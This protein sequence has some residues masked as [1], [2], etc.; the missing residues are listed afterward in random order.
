M[1][2][3]K[4]RIMLTSIMS[5][6]VALQLIFIIAARNHYTVDVVVGIYVSSTLWYIYNHKFPKDKEI[7]GYTPRSDYYDISEFNNY[8]GSPV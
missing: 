6:L 5:V 3:Q 4:A 7:D 8:G 1:G 2:S